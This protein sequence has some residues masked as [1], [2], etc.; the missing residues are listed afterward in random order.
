V[1]AALAADAAAGGGG[2]SAPPSLPARCVGGC[3]TLFIAEYMWHEEVHLYTYDLF[4]ERLGFK[5][6]WGCLCFYPCFYAVPLHAVVGASG[7]LSPGAAWAGVALFLCGWVFTRGANMQKFHAKTRGLAA[8]FLCGLVPLRAVPGSGGRLLCSGFWGLSRHVNYAGEVTQAVALA[9]MAT[10]AG[11]S[12][13]W[14]AWLYPAYYVAIFLPRQQDD[15]AMMEAKY[16]RE[17]WAAYTK[18]VPW[19]ILP[20]VY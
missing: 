4:R 9:A 20:G 10:G 2:S 1:L 15:D 16:G 19:R 12:R 17:V 3:L 14:V 11:G 7:G 6:L 8:P 5:L 13:A 18:E